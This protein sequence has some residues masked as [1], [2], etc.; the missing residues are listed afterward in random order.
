MKQQVQ[1]NM[2]KKIFRKPINSSSL[3][4]Q[5]YTNGYLLFKQKL[6]QHMIKTLTTVF[7]SKKW[8][9]QKSMIFEKDGLTPRSLFNIH[10]LQPSLIKTLIEGELTGLC[11]KLVDDDIYIYQS[12]INYKKGGVK[13]GEYWWHSDW[14]FWHFEDGMKEPLA[15]SLIFFLDSTNE[16]NGVLQVIPGSHFFIY[17]DQLSRKTRDPNINIRHNLSVDEKQN[18]ASEGLLT[19]E[20]LDKM[21]VQPI[22]V[23]AEPG[24]VLIMDAN[25]WHYSSENKSSK[26]RKALFVVLNSLK[27]RPEHIYRPDYLVE[28][29]IKV[30]L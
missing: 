4:E 5:Y 24:D 9:N 22:M 17:T 28:R 15:V 3:L 27:N 8:T 6:T 16:F 23:K 21:G 18:Y 19:K 11:K 30:L 20:D 7:S 2:V 14:I 29:K 26:E 1:T 25:L 12:H 10:N 13:G